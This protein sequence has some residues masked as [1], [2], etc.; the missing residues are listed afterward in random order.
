MTT[1]VMADTWYWI[2]RLNREGQW[3]EQAVA[4]NASL[5]DVPL[6]T[7]ELVLVE[8]LNFFAG[9]WLRETAA[10]LAVH[11]GRGRTAR[12]VAQTSVLW[13]AG[14]TLYRARPDKGYSLTDCVT[15]E[16]M[17]RSGIARVLTNDDHFRQ[18]GFEV[19]DGA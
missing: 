3:H 17:R 1:G 5:V 10:M 7:T 13:E 11:L 16:V 2:A 4:L 18:E 15:R 6:L 19:L 12:V 9:S 14:L 8:T